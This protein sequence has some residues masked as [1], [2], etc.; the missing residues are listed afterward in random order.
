LVGLAML[1]AALAIV[2]FAETSAAGRRAA[3]P[4]APDPAPVAVSAR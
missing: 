1:I 4:P 2:V 3:P